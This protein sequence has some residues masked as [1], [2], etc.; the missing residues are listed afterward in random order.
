[1][2]AFRS[3]SLLSLIGAL[4]LSAN[5]QTATQGATAPR[6]NT[7]DSFG[8]VVRTTVRPS[9][10]VSTYSSNSSIGGLIAQQGVNGSAKT[11]SPK[12]RAGYSNYNYGNSGYTNSY[13]NGYTNGYTNGYSNGYNNG[14]NNGYNNSP[15]SYYPPVR[16]PVPNPYGT[17]NNYYLPEPAYSIP[18]PGG[19]GESPTWITS[20]PLGTTTTYAAPPYAYPGYGYPAPHGVY[21]GPI[22]GAPA[23]G[24]TTTIYGGTGFGGVYSQ[25]QS[26]VFGVSIGRGGVSV[27]IGSQNSNSSTVVRPY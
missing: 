8:N 26:S 11:M 21:P 13:N 2:H 14:F 23:Y 1:M 16:Y 10:S 6:T 18:L 9:A 22:Y 4:A 15:N 25:S 17:T 24:S 3:L 20:I 12:L 5:A 27:K 7:V 19:A